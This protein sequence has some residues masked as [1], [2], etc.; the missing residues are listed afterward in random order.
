MAKLPL[1]RSQVASFLD[2]V[3]AHGVPSGM[4][5]V[6]F[7]PGQLAGLV[8]DGVNHF[9]AQPAVAVRRGGRRKKQSW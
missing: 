2:Q 5:G 6:T 4:W 3:L 8:P 7:N 9:R 1:H